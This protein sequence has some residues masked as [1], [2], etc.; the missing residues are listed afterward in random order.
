MVIKAITKP[1]ARIA[2]AYKELDDNVIEY[3]YSESTTRP[4]FSGIFTSPDDPEMYYTFRLLSYEGEELASSGKLKHNNYNAPDEHVFK[5]R[6]ANY[7]KYKV[8]YEVETQSGLVINANPYVFE[9]NES[10]LDK[11]TELTFRVDDSDSENG[12][13]NI[14][15]TGK[16]LTGFYIISRASEYEDFQDFEDIKVL[17]FND[18]TL[19]DEI[20]FYDYTIESGIK[21]I[22]AVQFYNQNGSRTIPLYEDN[23]PSRSINFEY[24][25]LYRDGI[26]LRLA[27]NHKIS[28]FKHT[29]L[30]SKQDTLG[31]KYP[32]LA[33]NGNAYYAEFPIAGTISILSDDN[34]FFNHKDE[35]YYYKDELIIPESKEILDGS[36]FPTDL[37]HENMFIERKFRDKVEEFLNDFTYKLYRSPTEGN[38][39]VVLHNVSMT[40]QASLGRMIFDFSATAY[41]MSDT[42]LASLNEYGI[43]NIGETAAYDL[44]HQEGILNFGQ[45]HGY[46][47]NNAELMYLIKQKEEIST[48][49]GFKRV[50]KQI[51]SL[52]FQ[53]YPEYDTK[54]EELE[55]E[56][57]IAELKK[58]EKLYDKEQTQLDV[59]RIIKDYNNKMVS[60]LTF[61]LVYKDQSTGLTI[62][63]DIVMAPNRIYR[64]DNISE[65]IY[66]IYLKQECPIVLNYVYTYIQE[67][68]E[69]SQ[70]NYVI[71]A[72]RLWGQFH[73]IFSSTDENLKEFNFYYQ[74]SPTYEYEIA[75]NIYKTKNILD[76]VEEKAKQEIMRRENTTFEKDKNNWW[77]NGDR[78]IFYRLDQIMK[79]D[80]QAAAGTML[81]INSKDFTIGP[82]GRYTLNPSIDL[83][84]S[85]AFKNPCFAIIDYKCM[86]SVQR[87]Q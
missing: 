65:Q 87:K 78:S 6:L 7:K 10:F 73:G 80:I 83:I 39:V 28:S 63:R 60:G 37:V 41:E 9:T 34:T 48:S 43:I 51:K 76:L 68:D 22:Y 35:G 50:I 85:I 36:A 31:S 55:L 12:R 17:F 81:T 46:Y 1:V 14:H 11:I 61:S 2:N 71:E 75:D 53:P 38:I 18:Q 25:Y 77:V 66:Q 27:F 44:T 8:T 5:R 24:A 86:V 69:S 29:V 70:E 52:W 19:E 62:S 59:I 49:R 4:K 58:E 20:V 13:M 67:Q 23:Q 21:Y 54:A 72:N 26:Q 40:P 45:I 3:L 64:L 42:N 32:Y 47:A 15:F 33:R 84:E 82:T 57:K 79:I 56:A 74:D 16:G 30:A